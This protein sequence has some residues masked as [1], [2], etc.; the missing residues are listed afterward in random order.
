MLVLHI[1]CVC[2]SD[3][4]SAVLWLYNP[5]ELISRSLSCSNNLLRLPCTCKHAFPKHLITLESY[6]VRVISLSAC[7]RR[8][9]GDLHNTIIVFHPNLATMHNANGSV[10]QLVAGAYTFA[11]KTSTAS[12]LW[13]SAVE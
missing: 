5:S 11:G 6:I 8:A 12:V 9:A 13:P 4:V 10:R 3:G 1:S 2:S 7:L